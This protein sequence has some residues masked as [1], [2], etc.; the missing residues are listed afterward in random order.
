M[1]ACEG[2]C[3]LDDALADGDRLIGHAIVQQRMQRLRREVL[4]RLVGESVVAA[5]WVLRA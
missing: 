2:G 4:G 1:L 5:S 3:C